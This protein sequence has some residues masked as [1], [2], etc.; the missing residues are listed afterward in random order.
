MDYHDVNVAKTII[1]GK[2][3]FLPDVYKILGRLIADNLQT[4][5]YEHLMK[6]FR[7]AAMP[8]AT[9]RK[10]WRGFN[11]AEIL[12]KSL[13]EIMG[14]ELIHPLER[15]KA[16]KTQKDLDR[17]NRQLNMKDA[18]NL[19]DGADIQGQNLI[20]VDDVVTTGATLLEAAK[21]LKRKGAGQ[22]WCVT[23]ARD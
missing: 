2:Y 6:D 10:R 22:V 17:V 18:F 9:S 4:N 19:I 13:S 8:L 3:H 16:T 21:V 14:K 12:C 7:F 1:F 11:Q 5:L 23:V 15:I 20:L